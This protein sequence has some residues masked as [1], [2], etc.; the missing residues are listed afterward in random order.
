MCP[1]PVEMSVCGRGPQAV[2]A[3][4]NNLSIHFPL[5]FQYASVSVPNIAFYYSWKL[6]RAILCQ[7]WSRENSLEQQLKLSVV[8]G[9]V[10]KFCH[11]CFNFE[12][13]H[14]RLLYY[15]LIEMSTFLLYNDAKTMHRRNKYFETDA[16]K[17]TW[18]KTTGTF[19]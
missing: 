17:D 13:R 16:L 19:S 8:R 6:D 15:P 14:D 1:F 18:G 4:I 12:N 9:W 5:T 10:R 2:M 11:R 7:F 3:F